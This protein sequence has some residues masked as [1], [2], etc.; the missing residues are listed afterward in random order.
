MPVLLLL[1]LVAGVAGLLLDP[2][3]ALLAT[4]VVWAVVFALA[5]PLLDLG[6][7]D[8]QDVD[9]WVSWLAFLAISLVLTR[10]GARRHRRRASGSPDTG[11]VALPDARPPRPARPAT[12]CY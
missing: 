1:I 11:P 4:V 7:A 10:V 3:P 8:Y 9:F 12:S 6:P 5:F 2:R